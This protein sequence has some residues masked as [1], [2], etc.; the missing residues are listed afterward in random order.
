MLR[1]RALLR[2]LHRGQAEQGERPHRQEANV[3]QLRREDSG[4]L[5]LPYRERPLRPA[6]RNPF[7]HEA[8]PLRSSETSLPAGLDQ[9]RAP[10]PR[11]GRS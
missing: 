1:H 4:R 6:H 9:V 2:E 10:G 8:D 11:D 3:R 5:R 7:G